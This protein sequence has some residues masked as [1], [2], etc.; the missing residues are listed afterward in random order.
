MRRKSVFNLAKEY[1]QN[2]FENY[3]S[4]SGVLPDYYKALQLHSI[5]VKLESHISLEV[6]CLSVESEHIS[7]VSRS[8]VWAEGPKP[9]HQQNA[10][11]HI[12]ALG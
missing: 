1:L 11:S 6:E 7:A 10:G 4:W 12:I 3:E 9:L 8:L 2:I 5:A